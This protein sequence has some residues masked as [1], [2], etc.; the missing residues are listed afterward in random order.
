MPTTDGSVK[1]NLWVGVSRR[2]PEANPTC[3]R[4]N[5]EAVESNQRMEANRR[6]GFASFGPQLCTT[7][8]PFGKNRKKAP[9]CGFRE[10]L[11]IRRFLVRPQEGQ[12]QAPLSLTSDG[13][14]CVWR[15]RVVRFLVRPDGLFGM[16][17]CWN[18]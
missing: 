17:P 13:G 15:G 6:S 16:P 8:N 3:K 9:G 11:W 1:R 10:R 5:S 14:V 4:S 7:A 12:L 2:S 18:T